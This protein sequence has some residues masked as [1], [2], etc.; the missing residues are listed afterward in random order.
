MPFNSHKNIEYSSCHEINFDPATPEKDKQKRD[1]CLL[2]KI[3]S[4]KTSQD[5]F[6]LRTMIHQLRKGLNNLQLLP[7]ISKLPRGWSWTY[8]N[9]VRIVKREFLL[10][11]ISATLQN[12]LTGSNSF[13]LFLNSSQH[14]DKAM[15]PMQHIQ[16]VDWL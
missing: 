13:A 7:K 1:K 8:K 6:M 14:T 15:S 5:Q 4:N 11:I 10:H 12:K 2:L 9:Y 3:K 16:W